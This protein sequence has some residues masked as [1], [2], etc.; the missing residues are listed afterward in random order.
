MAYVTA[1][2]I[3]L[4]LPH[5]RSY[6]VVVISDISSM[7]WKMDIILFGLKLQLQA[8]ENDIYLSFMQA[9]TLYLAY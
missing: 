9:S 2:N 6:E 5:R 8:K 7:A 1:L 4:P 3:Q